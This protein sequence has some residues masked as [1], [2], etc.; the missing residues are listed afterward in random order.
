MEGGRDW[1]RLGRGLEIPD[2]GF[3]A[4]ALFSCSSRASNSAVESSVPSSLGSCSSVFSSPSQSTLVLVVGDPEAL[5]LL[6]DLGVLGDPLH[7]VST[8]LWH[9]SATG[10][11]VADGSQVSTSMT[12]SLFAIAV[13]MENFS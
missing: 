9:D 8:G 11:V 4:R 2:L 13:S 3:V 10:L 7:N 12:F 6:L 1:L 5:L